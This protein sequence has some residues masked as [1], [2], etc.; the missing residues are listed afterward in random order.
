MA[1]P[2]SYLTTFM[3]SSVL[4]SLHL[5]SAGHGFGPVEIT[6][7]A[8]KPTGF[9]DMARGMCL[10]GTFVRQGYLYLQRQRGG[11]DKTK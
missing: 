9:G 5:Y 10:L 1:G 7:L 6:E 11:I 8:D 4:N 2:L 3:A